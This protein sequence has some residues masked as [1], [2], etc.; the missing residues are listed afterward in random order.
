MRENIVAGLILLGIGCLL[1]TVGLVAV[2]IPPEGL[3]FFTT[4][5]VSEHGR[6]EALQV[7][8]FILLILGAVAAPVGVGVL[9]LELIKRHRNR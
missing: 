2:A 1:L 9:I 4:L 6:C 8:G 7:T 5:N 3:R